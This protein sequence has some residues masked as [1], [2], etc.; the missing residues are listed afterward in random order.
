MENIYNFVNNFYK[1]M[2]YMFRNDINY[3]KLKLN[4][5]FTGKFFKEKTNNN[6]YTVVNK[7]SL[8]RSCS[9]EEFK[10]KDE[11]IKEMQNFNN[12][13]YCILKLIVNDDDIIFIKNNQNIII[14]NP[15]FCVLNNITDKNTFIKNLEEFKKIKYT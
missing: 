15:S 9:F 6:Y 4:E 13:K 11:F 1:D 14:E 8:T 2:E 7:N 10:C 5:K 3:N 12:E